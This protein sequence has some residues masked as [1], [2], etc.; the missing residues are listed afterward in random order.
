MIGNFFFFLIILLIIKYFRLL[1]KI[2][3]IYDLP[4]EKRKIHTK[5]V[6]R[7]GGIFFFTALLLIFLFKLDSISYL[8]L[9]SNIN[10]VLISFLL[11]FLG[12]FDDKFN[13]KPFNKFFFLS[14]FYSL[15]LFLEKNLF[16]EYLNLSSIN[17]KI[18]LS[19]FSFFFTLLCF[20][21]LYI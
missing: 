10:F 8:K 9:Y 7:F 12:F 3:N 11:F 5:K 20:I 16:I 1:E 14:I 6:S 18:N 17:F 13:L 2:L 15:F 4:N 21:I 19:Y